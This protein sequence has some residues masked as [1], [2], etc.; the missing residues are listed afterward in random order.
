MRLID[1][2]A[3]EELFRDVIG[4]IFREQEITGN[5]EHMVRASAMCIQMIQDA[6]TVGIRCK[7][8]RKRITIYCPFYKKYKGTK[9]DDWFCADGVKKDD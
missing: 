5:L 7:D 9:Y 6:P 3:L 8:C 2:D 4:C 1:A